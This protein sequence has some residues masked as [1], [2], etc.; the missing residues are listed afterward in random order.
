MTAR[1]AYDIAVSLIR[2]DDLIGLRDS[3]QSQKSSHFYMLPAHKTIGELLVDVSGLPPPNARAVDEP[4]PLGWSDCCYIAASD[5]DSNLL[6][7]PYEMSLEEATS[8][9]GVQ[10]HS[11]K[12]A[13][14]LSLR[15]VLQDHSP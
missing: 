3:E 8:K 10:Q 5:K 9:F 11:C 4:R 2:G 14:T 15:L 12:R 13:A 1:E 6:P 7:L